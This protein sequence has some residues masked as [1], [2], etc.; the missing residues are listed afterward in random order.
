MKLYIE[1]N[2]GAAGDMLMAA[3]FEL[4][5]EPQ[6][7]LARMRALG[8][9]GVELSAEPSVKCG[10]RGTHMSVRISGAE[11]HS[12]D[13]HTHSHS[14]EHSHE[15]HEHSHGE[16]GHSHS[17][18][19][20]SYP[21]ILER[22]AAL[23]ISDK[24]RADA[25]AVYKLLAEAESAVHGQ[26][27]EQIHFHEVGS[28]DAL[29]DIVGVC[30]AVDMLGLSQI[31]ASAIHVGSGNVRCAHGI[32]PVPT[33]ATAL[34][35]QGIPYYSGAIRGE[36]CTPTGA[37]LLRHFVTS[38]GAAPVMS[39]AKIGYG[40]GSKDFEA[41]NCVRAFLYEDTQG[42]DSVV[43]INCNIDDMTAEAIGFA[44]EELLSAG[45]LD[46][47]LTPVYAKKNRPA[48]MM[49]LLCHPEDEERF[50]ALI[51]RH[52]TTLGLRKA[53][54]RRATLSRSFETRET[55]F[56]SVSVKVSEGFGVRREKPE[57]DDLARLA[58]ENDVPLGEVL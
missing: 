4:L 56:G 41:A 44:V 46:V 52:T 5:P 49:T 27:I 14:G 45:A 26:P 25:R 54:L 13:V 20:M 8:L 58:R 50:T 34:L 48:T 3:L 38:F 31:S 37:A 43:E 29:A 10:I 22:I 18:T 12:H 6:E 1:C 47:F 17:H 7:F 16:G 2:M 30:L 42:G 33:P 9:P 57:F 24:A 21:E 19:A 15:H 39:V 28:L 53:T 35:L 32:L 36:L 51:F 11:E 40:M 23:D 55:R